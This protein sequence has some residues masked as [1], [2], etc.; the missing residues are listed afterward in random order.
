VTAKLTSW[1]LLFFATMILAGC[2]A[3]QQAASPSQ[4]SKNGNGHLAGGAP[5]SGGGTG[6]GGARLPVMLAE[7]RLPVAQAAA[8]RAVA[9]L[10]APAEVATV[11]A[12]TA[13]EEMVV[14][15]TVATAVRQAPTST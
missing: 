14:A 5:G 7:V 6:S 3:T 8:I 11:A 15:A 13:V 4:M 2:S 12:G 10:V 1:I 9:T